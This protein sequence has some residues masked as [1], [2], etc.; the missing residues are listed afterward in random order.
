MIVFTIAI[1]YTS[2][3]VSRIN[4]L[5]GTVF[6]TKHWGIEINIILIDVI[7]HIANSK[8]H[9]KELIKIADFQDYQLT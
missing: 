9:C 8:R 6:G 1:F 4:V 7:K 2:F 5:V 3:I